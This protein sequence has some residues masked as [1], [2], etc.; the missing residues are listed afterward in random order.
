MHK[1]PQLVSGMKNKDGKVS[2]I[3]EMWKIKAKKQKEIGRRNV[4]KMS[5]HRF[6]HFGLEGKENNFK[7]WHYEIDNLVESHNR[8]LI[9]I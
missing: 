8:A 4:Q 7:C 9:S 2:I 5:G 1:A 3:W 6:Q